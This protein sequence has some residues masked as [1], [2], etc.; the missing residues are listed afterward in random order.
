MNI[1]KTKAEQ[2]SATT[3]TPS[4]ERRQGHLP[5][6]TMLSR[7][8]VESLRQEAHRDALWMRKK[9]VEMGFTVKSPLF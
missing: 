1:P 4:T 5:A 8:E 9:L 3:A 2:K 7:S 6:T